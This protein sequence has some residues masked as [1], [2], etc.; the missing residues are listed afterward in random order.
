MAMQGTKAT[1]T[2]LGM[3]VFELVRGYK[4][5]RYPA[6]VIGKGG[7]GSKLRWDVDLVRDVIR[8]EM[9]SNLDQQHKA[10]CEGR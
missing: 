10:Y 4:E 8:R 1:A 9:L 6:V 7:R 5:G 3:S 2:E